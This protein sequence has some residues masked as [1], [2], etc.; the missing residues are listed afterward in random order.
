MTRPMF[1]EIK[2]VVIIDAAPEE[3]YEAYVDPTK[4]A[5]FTGSPA[6]GKPRAGCKFTSWDGYISPAS[7]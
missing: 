2:Q 6:T 1:V 7:M 5:A 3:V 4:H